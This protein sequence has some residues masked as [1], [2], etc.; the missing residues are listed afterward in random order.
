MEHG[1]VAGLKAIINEI[2]QTLPSI[3]I[4]RCTAMVQIFSDVA[5]MQAGQ[6]T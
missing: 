6:G 4:H 1:T 2:L 3:A 5:V